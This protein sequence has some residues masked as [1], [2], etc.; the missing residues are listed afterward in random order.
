MPITPISRTRISEA[1]LRGKDCE[2]ITPDDSNDLAHMALGFVL[3]GS[4]GVVKLTTATGDVRTTK[5]LPAG[6][7]PIGA[8]RIWATGT[9][10][11]EITAIY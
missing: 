9:T 5:D 7:Y 2:A 3:G 1:D 4:G 8:I 6:T 11:T 10:A